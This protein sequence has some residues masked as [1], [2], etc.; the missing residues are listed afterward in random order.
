MMAATAFSTRFS[1]SGAMPGGNAWQYCLLALIVACLALSAFFASSEGDASE[2]VATALE[3]MSL[4]MAL[5]VIHLFASRLFGGHPDTKPAKKIQDAHEGPEGAAEAE[6]PAAEGTAIESGGEPSLEEF[7]QREVGALTTKI[8][9]AVRVGDMAGAEALMERM[10]ETCGRPGV[11]RRA[12]WAVSYGELV[13]GFV[14][15]RDPD[16]AGRW[17]DVFAAAAPAIR[18]STVCCNSVIAAFGAKGN[19]AGA[20]ACVV[21]MA[22]VGVRIDEETYSEVIGACIAAGDTQRAARWLREMRFSG[23]RPG[24]ELHKLVLQA[25]ANDSRGGAAS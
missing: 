18:P 6:G 11:L 9:A 3:E 20:E 8:R 2:K 22:S 21:R 12:C 16:S 14:K 13:S 10:Q 23:L 4:V 15:R 25:C 19:A 7:Q 17:L 24:A 1:A 5:L